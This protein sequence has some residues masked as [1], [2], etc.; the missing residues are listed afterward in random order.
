M[1]IRG[2]F[3][4]GLRKNIAYQLYDGRFFGEFAQVRHFVRI[5]SFGAQL[6]QLEQSFEVLRFH[7]MPRPRVIG[8]RNRQCL[9]Q[10]TVYRVARST[11]NDAV[12]TLPNNHLL[13]CE[14]VW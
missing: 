3:V 7:E 10:K 4:D 6:N 12:G 11:V 14:P 8:Q 9:L 5:L 13:I 2:T 1:N